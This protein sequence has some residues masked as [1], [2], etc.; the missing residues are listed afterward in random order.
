PLVAEI[1]FPLTEKLSWAKPCWPMAT[2][3]NTTNPKARPSPL[4]A[5]ALA[6]VQ[7]HD[8]S[9]FLRQLFDCCSRLVRQSFD[10]ASTSVRLAFDKPSARLREKGE[11]KPSSCR[12]VALP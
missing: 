2:N 1:T 4:W 11:A 12:M 3:S 10:N 5:G 8:S 6:W 9:I 7:T